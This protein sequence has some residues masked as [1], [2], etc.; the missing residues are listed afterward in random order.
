MA[1]YLSIPAVGLSCAITALQFVL[2]LHYTPQ[3]PERMKTH[4]R[5]GRQQNAWLPRRWGLLLGP[6]VSS[7]VTGL[8]VSVG[9]QPGGGPDVVVFLCGQLVFLAAVRWV[10]I[11]NVRL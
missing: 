11:Q 3:M 9:S 10:Y 1:P 2:S 4:F 5:S 7:S 6:I 8:T